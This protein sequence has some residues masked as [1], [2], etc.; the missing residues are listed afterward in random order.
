MAI[1]QAV[2]DLLADQHTA[3]IA[4]VD[5][6]GL[7]AAANLYYALAD[8]GA[9]L[10]VRTDPSSAHATNWLRS[11]VVALTVFAHPD[12]PRAVVRGVQLRGVVVGA[13]RGDEQLYDRRYPQARDAAPADAYFRIA[14]NWCRLLDRV[15]G[16]V[17][18]EVVVVDG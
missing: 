5:P 13:D 2:R 16:I 15:A 11:P 7:P 4:T 18:E 1:I 12:T 3:G 6:E 17:A 9:D 8:A 10:V 14:V